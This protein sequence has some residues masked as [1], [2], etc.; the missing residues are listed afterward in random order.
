MYMHIYIYINIIIYIN[1]YPCPLLYRFLCES[2][3]TVDT[4]QVCA[5]RPRPDFGITSL[6]QQRN[7]YTKKV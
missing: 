1:I 2:R 3:W 6:K 4:R 7:T 5:L